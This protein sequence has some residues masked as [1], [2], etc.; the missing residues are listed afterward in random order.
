MST[1]KERLIKNNQDLNNIKTQVH[2]LPEYLDTSDATA[3]ADDIAKN[4]TAYVNG[5]KITGNVKVY[6]KSGATHTGCFDD[7]NNTVI[8]NTIVENGLTFCAKGRYNML[9][10]QNTAF[11]GISALNT[12][13]ASAINLTADKLKKDEVV[14]GVTGTYEGF[15][16]TYTEMSFKTGD[17]MVIDWNMI[18]NALE[19]QLTAEEKAKDIPMDSCHGTVLSIGKT[20]GNNNIYFYLNTVS[21]SFEFNL[22]DSVV[23][24]SSFTSIDTT[25]WSMS[26]NSMTVQEFIDNLKTIP[27]N[28]KSVCIL[29]TDINVFD[30]KISIYFKDGEFK[31][32][33]I[34][35]SNYL[36]KESGPIPPTPIPGKTIQFTQGDTVMINWAMIIDAMET[37]LTSAEK[38]KVLYG[39]NACSEYALQLAPV[40]EDSNS[41]GFQI[42]AHDTGFILYDTSSSIFTPETSY[43]PSYTNVTA[44]NLIDNL[45][46][47]P[48]SDRPI[49]TRTTGEYTLFDNHVVRLNFEDGTYK[50]ITLPG[51]YIFV[52]PTDPYEYTVTIGGNIKFNGASLASALDSQLT[53]GEKAKDILIDGSGI[54]TIVTGFYNTADNYNMYDTHNPRAGLETESAGNGMMFSNL[55]VVALDY[56]EG[57]YTAQNLINLLVDDVA[58][59]DLTGEWVTYPNMIELVFDDETRKKIWLTEP[60][61]E[62]VQNQ[63]YT[64]PED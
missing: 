22:Y 49:V 63:G 59:V 56:F 2:N 58:P 61:F 30:S 21:G 17:K 23:A 43:W 46:L 57:N 8:R 35:S 28:D 15:K 10:R 55:F 24:T 29:D 60:V 25:G 18:A 53:A 34:L 42:W 4:T 5:Q 45:K 52:N 9:I 62:I 19:S 51:D 38:A 64:T 31:D 14:L 33:A 13:I 7:G 6:D 1:N 36:T 26:G 11:V 47:T 32:I 16:P 50:D 37:Q 12:D 40:Y 48:V 27:A 41:L 39:T 3:T 54:P 20:T 44:Q